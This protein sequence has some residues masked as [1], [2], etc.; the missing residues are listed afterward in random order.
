MTA[1]QLKIAL[2]LA[3]SAALVALPFHAT[4]VI[5]DW[6]LRFGSLMILSVSWN[7]AANAG[8][9][10]LGHSAFWGLGTYVAILSTNRLG[11]TFAESILPSIAVGAVVGALLAIITGRLRGFFFA[12]STLALSEGLR[13]IA[14]MTPDITGGGEGLYVDQTHRPDS[15]TIASAVMFFA[16]L[17]FG[18]AWAMFRSRYQYAFRAMR[19]NEP[20]SQMFGINPSAFR[21]GVLTISGGMASLAGGINAWFGGF[22][23]PN[24]AFDLHITI[25]AQVAPILGGIYT[26]MGPVIGSFAAIGISEATR[27][28]FGASG[29]SLFIYG[30]ILC[31][32]ILYLPNGIWGGLSSWRQRRSAAHAAA[33]VWQ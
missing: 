26:L 6:C 32:C 7:I 29:F 19:N 27:I 8:L 4:P 3:I 1:T 17:V 13:V 21:I 31:I 15:N 23:D 14:V 16:C 18:I 20:A 24:I 25:L 11:L 12:I 22:V 2:F 9:V 33:E 10:S 5:T 28:W 30:F